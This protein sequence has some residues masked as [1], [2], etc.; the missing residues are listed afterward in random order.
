VGEIYALSSLLQKDGDDD[1]GKKK[2]KNLKF[3]YLYGGASILGGLGLMV[4]IMGSVR[5]SVGFEEAVCN[6]G[7]PNKVHAG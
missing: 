1:D 5:W 4:V 3:A 7:Y 2:K 6:T